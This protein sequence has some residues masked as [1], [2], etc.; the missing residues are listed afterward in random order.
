MSGYAATLASSVT[1]N[2]SGGFPGPVK[3]Q[4]S[5]VQ[6]TLLQVS[7]FN[8]AGI[9]WEDLM[10]ILN[11]TDANMRGLLK[12]I[13]GFQEENPMME[14]FDADNFLADLISHVED[15]YNNTYASLFKFKTKLVDEDEANVV[16]AQYGE[17][18][19]SHN[20]QNDDT[21]TPED[22]DQHFMTQHR[23][24]LINDII[25]VKVC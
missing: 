22:A 15:V 25:K 17:E 19:C 6:S 11:H 7:G 2:M 8:V 18:Q 1:G 24:I 5:A 4:D 21:S 16:V 3:I 14:N 12:D 23:D 13:F 20:V 10:P 9:I